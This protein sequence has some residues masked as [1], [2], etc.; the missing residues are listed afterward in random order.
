MKD[1]T[2]FLILTLLGIL[3]YVGYIILIC[4]RGPCLADFITIGINM[5]IWLAV[6]LIPD[7]FK[8]RRA[9]KEQLVK[10]IIEKMHQEEK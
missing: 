9:E 7:Y 4:F 10:E 1:S 3:C 8:L 5:F 6:A 2:K